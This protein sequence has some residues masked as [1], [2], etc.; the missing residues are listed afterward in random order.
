LRADVKHSSSFMPEHGK[1]TGQELQ[2]KLEAVAGVDRAFVHLDTECDH[3]AESEH[4][5]VQ[6][7]V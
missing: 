1:Q 4:K 5:I 3:T 6:F 7:E 2:L